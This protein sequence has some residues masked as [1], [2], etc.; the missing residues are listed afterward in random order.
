MEDD[1]ESRTQYLEACSG[2]ASMKQFIL[3]Q[4]STIPR[5]DQ[6]AT[7]HVQHLEKYMSVLSLRKAT[8]QYTITSYFAPR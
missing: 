1:S 3:E 6:A 4:G 7:L 5:E 2:L 8:K